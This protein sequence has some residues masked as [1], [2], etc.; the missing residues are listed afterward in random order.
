[1]D[2]F[3]LSDNARGMQVSEVRELMK[4]GSRPGI[5]NLAGGNPDAESFPVREVTGIIDAWTDAKARAAFQYGATSG[6][7]PLLDLL[8][9]RM[10]AQGVPMQEQKIL[11]TTGA[12][13][14]LYLTAKTLI[15]PGDTIL[16][17]SPTFIGAIAAF[18]SLRAELEWVPLEEDGLS[19]TETEKTLKRLLKENRVPK[20]IYTIPN[21]QNPAGL[22]L[23][24]EKRRAL[25][26]LALEY[27]VPILE[28]DPYGELFFEG[29]RED[30]LPIKVLDGAEKSVILVNTFSK[31]LS[32]GMRLGWIT[33]D[34]SIVAQA[35][36][37][38]QSV[39]A[40]SN[41]YTQVVAA[42]YL[43]TG[44]VETYVQSMR[45]IYR[46]KAQC[47]LAALGKHMPPSCTWSTP[48]G[49]FFIWVTLPQNIGAKALF[50]QCIKKNAAFVTG[51]AFCE[52]GK[53]DRYIRLAFSNSTLT[54]IEK[55]VE[56][57]GNTMKE[58]S[59]P[60][61]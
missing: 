25:L 13:Q 47:M 51:H 17:E 10:H 2:L 53:G 9:R 59:A 15:N 1:M 24:Q 52:A 38:K 36:I 50:E 4:M 19:I 57:I 31:I 43:E 16:V 20:F 14:A 56:I 7:P 35:E 61:L 48:K 27:A 41:S 18:K 12:Q 49:G 28:D 22:T 26:Q 5:I 42:D 44:M 8:A 55:G 60:I 40:C 37:A 29:K 46:E 32:P 34:E 54:N 6:Y 58:M 21:F 3:K 30:Y 23:S 45:A 39:D 33:G 11:V